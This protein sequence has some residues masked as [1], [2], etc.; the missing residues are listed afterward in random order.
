MRRGTGPYV[1]L[2]HTISGHGRLCFAGAPYRLRAGQTMLLRFPH[3]HRYWLPRGSEWEFFWLCLSGREVLRI[4]RDAIAAH[5]P[6][7][8]LSTTTLDQIAGLCASVLDGAASSPARASAIAYN[9]AMLLADELLPTPEMSNGAAWP[10]GIGRAVSLAQVASTER[11][12]VAALAE[13]A[14]YSRHHFSRVFRASEGVS[15][16]RYVLRWRMDEAV[17]M[18]RSGVLPIKTV[19]RRCGFQDPNYF[20]KVFRRLFGVTPGQFRHGG[21]LRVNPTARR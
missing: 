2:Q 1:L 15:P 4:W 14:G 13:T 9:A 7:V 21:A 6:V 18:L 11:P 5:G 19:A 10:G 17:V 8:Q 12:N 20:G 3:D 16:A